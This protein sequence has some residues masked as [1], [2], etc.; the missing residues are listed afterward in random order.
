MNDDFI[1]LISTDTLLFPKKSM[2]D[3]DYRYLTD[4]ISNKLKNGL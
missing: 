2:T 1:S 4:F 3:S